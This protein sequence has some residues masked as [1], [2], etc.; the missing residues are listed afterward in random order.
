M[1]ARNGVVVAAFLG[2][3]WVVAHVAAQGA[4]PAPPAGG[5][6]RA[7]GQ[8]R[9]GGRG[10]A[11]FPAQQRAPGD[12]AVVA[13]GKALYEMNCQSC[14]AADLRG[15]SGP[16]LLRSQ[17][18]LSDQQGELIGPVVHGSMA[19]MKA[20]DLSADDVKTLTVFIHEIVRG[21]RNQGAPP[22][23]GVP[24]ENT[25]VGD[26][27]AG[28]TYF[29]ANCASCHSLTGDLQNIGSKMP[30]GKALQNLWVSGGEVGGSG[31]GRRGGRGAAPAP[32]KRTPTV[33]VT[34]ASSSPVQGS[35]VRIDDF[36]VTI[37]QADG[38]VRTFRRDPQTKVDIKDPLEAHHKLLYVDR[39]RDA[40][41]DGLPGDREMTLK[42]LLLLAPVLLGSVVLSGQGQGLD[43]ADILKPLK[44]SWP[45]YNGDYTGRR[46]SLLT[47][48]TRRTVKNLTLGWTPAHV[49]APGRRGVNVGGE[50][51]GDFPAG[52]GDDQS[53]KG[54]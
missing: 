10:P 9:P 18:V 36:L 5:G 53:I 14:H 54:A 27:A 20:I 41:R 4:P 24:V 30:D 28:K 23:P 39:Q 38:T 1:Q 49:M 40:R 33:T 19:G 42:K 21:A 12:P 52:N 22:G 32:D 35:L 26:A 34:P 37:M 8:G 7:Q 31:G 25:I 3:T 17:I 51:S 16:N 6:G 2:L 46:Y 47:R 43:P 50:G 15:A 44:D 29:Q 48:S 11:T 13:R 45:T